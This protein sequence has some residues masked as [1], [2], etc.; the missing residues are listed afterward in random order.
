MTAVLGI[1]AYYH[2]SA[3]ALLVD[4]E[5]VAAAQEERFSRQKHDARFPNQAINYCMSH[6]G[7]GYAD[8]DHVAFYEKPFRKFE[9]LLETYLAI[10]PSGWGSFARSM[11]T[12]LRQKLYLSREIQQQL[13]RQ[14]GGRII[15]PEHHES[16]AASAF[17]A[18]PFQNAAIL[19]ADGVGE[20]ATTT[21]GR[22]TENGIELLDQIEFPHSLGLLYSAF[23][24]Y[25]GFRINS[26]EAK[27][28]G[29]A[30]F[31]KPR[32]S[33]RIRETLMDIKPDGSFRL[34]LNY[35][36][37]HKGLTM[38]SRRFHQLFE[39]PPRDPETEITQ[40]VMDLAA[41]VQ[42]VVEDILLKMAQH[43]HHKTGLEN[44]CVAGG[45][46]LNCVANGQLRRKSP[47]QN[48][49]VQPAA[50]DAG[51][52]L[53]AALFVWHQLLGNDKIQA[54]SS[55]TGLPVYTGPAF[56]QHQ[57]ES[58]I[59]PS[60]LAESPQIEKLSFH[61]NHSLCEKVTELLAQEKV[62]GWFKGRM[63]FGPRA[64]GNRSIIADPRCPKMQNRINHEI[65]FRESF[66]PFA[67]VVLASRADRFFDI[68]AHFESPYMLF[69][70]KLKPIPQTAPAAQSE[71]N[72]SLPLPAITHINQS[73]RLQTVT[74]QQNDNLAQLL[75]TF[76]GK[77]GCP[78]LLNTS[79][80]VRGQPIACSPADALAIFST[81][82]LDA[83]V[84]ENALLVKTGDPGPLPPVGQQGQPANERPNHPQFEL[85]RLPLTGAAGGL[86]TYGLWGNLSWSL[87]IVSISLLLFATGLVAPRILAP[88]VSAL[89]VAIRFTAILFTKVM[90][91]LVFYLLLTP[92]ALLLRILGHRGL[93]TRFESDSPSYWKHREPVKSKSSY[94]RQ[95]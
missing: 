71:S 86:I 32:F 16:H 80:N 92:Y 81:T 22:G 6:A 31:G 82:A 54:A 48:I 47:F 8:L 7:L 30:P 23:T 35:F 24:T 5:L 26:G 77:T 41:S 75:E 60:G 51:G 63:E 74:H 38:T 64:L 49:W 84:M 69:A 91:L 20:W 58:A 94:F 10:A 9:R 25:C 13:N 4:G 85:Y 1:S 44:L 28:M 93:Q 62:V 39:G 66:R 56:N 59:Q 46:G 53:G 14:F 65:K 61:D 29:L 50:G 78:V 11:P 42:S 55:S 52:A 3:A 36:N 2:D 67:P 89:G 15:F 27:L 79:L 68:P 72:Q 90:M 73:A 88:L 21:L 45:L 76:E 57:I 43:L 12:W 70:E 37:F 17:F 34:D 19:T 87:L 33:D 18:S 83:L 40:R 95:F